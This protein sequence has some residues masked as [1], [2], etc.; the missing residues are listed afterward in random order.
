[1]TGWSRA[2]GNFCWANSWWRRLCLPQWPGGVQSHSACAGD[3]PINLVLS[4]K[5]M[6]IPWYVFICLYQ[7]CYFKLFFW[8]KKLPLPVPSCGPESPLAVTELPSL[9]S[10]ELPSIKFRTRTFNKPWSIYLLPTPPTYSILLLKAPWLWGWLSGGQWGKGGYHWF[11][12]LSE[13]FFNVKCLVPF[14][15]FSSNIGLK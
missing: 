7:E 15:L 14:I 4:L 5:V 12:N 3:V 6:P 2:S 10:T 13:Y 8:G 1:M 11:W 9:S